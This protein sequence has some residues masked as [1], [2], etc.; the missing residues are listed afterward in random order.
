M[1]HKPYPTPSEV[2]L[3]EKDR[4]ILHLLIEEPR[5]SVA[6]I[7]RKV[8]AQR[9]TVIYRMKRFEKKGLIL[10]Y[11]IV[12]D[13]AAL[14]LDIFML[15]LV[16]T[17]PVSQPVLDEFVDAL[18]KQKHVTHVAKLVGKYDFML[19]MAAPDMAAFDKALTEV[20]SIQEGVVT[21]IEPIGVSEAYKIDDFSA[22]I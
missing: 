17:A 21:E 19:Y 8:G 3:D 13:S 22:L 10:K 18:M 5:I 15:V 6:D 1:E 20:K 4:K 2:N 16:K 14:G 7:A 9:D 12:I 11:H